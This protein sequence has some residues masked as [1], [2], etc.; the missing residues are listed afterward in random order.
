LYHS[1]IFVL[2][3]NNS[4]GRTQLKKL[5]LKGL[6]PFPL[7][8]NNSNNRITRFSI[9]ALAVSKINKRRIVAGWMRRLLTDFCS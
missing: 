9:S 2:V 7:K 5:V 1:Y 6:N 3:H 4:I 8:N